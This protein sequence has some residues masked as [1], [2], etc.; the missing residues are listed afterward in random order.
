MN[1]NGK[2]DFL[3]NFNARDF[4]TQS[5]LL[6]LSL[7]AIST[8]YSMTDSNRLES[9]LISEAYNGNVNPSIIA[10]LL[11]FVGIIY[12]GLVFLDPNSLKYKILIVN[13]FIA[14]LSWSVFS[15]AF[16]SE[17]VEGRFSRLIIITGYNLA[18]CIMA[19]VGYYAR[20][21]RKKYNNSLKGRNRNEKQ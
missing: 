13:S 2:R 18:V 20:Q 7:F 19:I 4:F 9:R 17:I 21:E 12:F 10:F 5:V 1:N 16:Y 14:F 6:V 15:A 11:I 8:G 3:L